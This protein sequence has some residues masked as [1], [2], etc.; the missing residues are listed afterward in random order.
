MPFISY[1]SPVG[2]L[3]LFQEDDAIIALD[4]GW[5]PQEESTPLLEQARD[6]L[7]DYFLKKRRQFDLPLQPLGGSAFQTKV[8]QALTAIP[9]GQTVTYGQLAQ[10]L[11]TSPRAI[12]T[13]VGRNPLPILIPC[14]RVLGAHGH[15]G[16]YSG[17]DGVE[18]KQALL[19]LEGVLA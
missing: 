16:G 18:T 3:S 8:W 12:G 5:P 1:N 4:W 17:L 10:Q 7:A 15:L 19:R 11:E 13:A 6:Q 14:H 9:W 2:P